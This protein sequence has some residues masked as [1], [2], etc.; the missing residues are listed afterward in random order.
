MK[1]IPVIYGF[2]W[3]CLLSETTILSVIVYNCSAEIY[4]ITLIMLHANDVIISI[5]N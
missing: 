5:R 3:D 2:L 1:I 4:L